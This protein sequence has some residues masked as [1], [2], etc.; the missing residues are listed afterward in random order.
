MAGYKIAH[1][2]WFLLEDQSFFNTVAQ[3]CLYL[4]LYF[5][6]CNFHLS[7]SILVNI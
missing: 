6:A 1:I 7:C 2:L 5:S 3:Y 4:D